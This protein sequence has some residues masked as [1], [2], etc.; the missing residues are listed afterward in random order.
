MNILLFALY[1]FCGFMMAIV[2]CSGIGFALAALLALFKSFSRLKNFLFALGYGVAAVVC[3]LLIIG[4]F[5]M[6]GWIGDRT[7]H[8]GQA[9]LL[10]GAIFPGIFALAIIPQFLAVARKQT[11]G[12]YVE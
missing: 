10:I 5:H 12:I 9:G 11:S 4:G 6:A 7:Q 8:G 2:A 3:Y 1:W